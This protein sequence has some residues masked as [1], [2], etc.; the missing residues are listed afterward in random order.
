MASRRWPSPAR[1]ATSASSSS[2]P[3]T[4]PAAPSPSSA[5]H[6]TAEHVA[7]HRGHH[8]IVAWLVRDPQ[9][10]GAPPPRVPH[11]RARA[12]AAA[13]RRRPRRRRRAPESRRSARPRPDRGGGRRAAEGT[14]AFLVL[15][16]AKPWSRKTHKYFP[17]PARARAVELWPWAFRFSRRFAREE[18]AMF[19]VWM[20][21]VMGHEVTRDYRPLG[22]RSKN[23]WA[24]KTKGL[25][26][27]VERVLH[28]CT[29]TTAEARRS[30]R[31]VRPRAP[32]LVAAR[33]RAL[34]NAAPGGSGG[35]SGEAAGEARGFLRR[36]CP[37]RSPSPPRRAHA[38][39]RCRGG[40]GGAV[41]RGAER[42]AAGAGR[43]DRRGAGGAARGG[44]RGV[45]VHHRAVRQ[46]VLHGH[47]VLLAREAARGVR[48]TRGAGGPT[49]SSTSR[50]RTCPACAPSSPTG[51]D[52]RRAFGREVVRHD[53]PRAR[54]HG[55][56][57][58]EPLDRAVR[59]HDQGAPPPRAAATPPPPLQAAAACTA[60]FS[61]RPP[62]RRA[63]RPPPPLTAL[64]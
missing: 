44:V 41:E 33:R 24:R 61:R 45:P 30:S 32:G 62:A 54:R 49:T 37:R 48:G 15:E 36:G 13:R 43:R 40:A 63:A 1:T 28:S 27:G 42:R 20:T 51:G 21:I 10:D 35:L 11:A 52:E 56:K 19:D 6:D 23:L 38:R 7:T 60:Q 29:S 2:S 50:G 34:L 3:P 18:Q 16:A 26:S 22:G 5:P 46:D 12:R 53:R 8:A 25:A 31:P 58:P 64:P 55:A 14:A 47:Q 59:G 17:E 4:A 39:P 57:L 9:L